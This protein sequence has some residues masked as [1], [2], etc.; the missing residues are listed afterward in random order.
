MVRPLRELE[1][2]LTTT[3]FGAGVVLPCVLF[4]CPVCED[5]HSHLIPYGPVSEMVVV[6]DGPSKGR[7]VLVW[8]HDSGDSIDDITLSPS[9]LVRGACNVHG[10]VRGGRWSSC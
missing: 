10:F 7:K 5:R 4:V 1:G 9:Y 8:K 6:P 3:D 2:E